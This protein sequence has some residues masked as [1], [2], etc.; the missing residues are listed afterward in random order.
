MVETTPIHGPSIGDRITSHDTPPV[1]WIGVAVF[2]TA[3]DR[4]DSVSHGAEFR[5]G[6]LGLLEGGRNRSPARVHLTLEITAIVLVVNLVFAH[7]R[8]GSRASTLCRANDA[9]RDHRFAVL[10]SPVIAGFMLILLF[11]PS[12]LGIFF[13]TMG[14]KCCCHARH[15][16]GDAFAT[17]PFVSPAGSVTDIGRMPRKQREHWGQTSGKCF[18]R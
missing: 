18:S 4:P 10:V 7:H 16:A 11:G 1:H 14:S 3:P 12:I 6:N 13:G 17:F 15:G 8:P 2:R 9:E 5:R